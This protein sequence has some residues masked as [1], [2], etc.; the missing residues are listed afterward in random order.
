MI[1]IC[2]LSTC[3]ISSLNR[4]ILLSPS[5]A[6]IFYLFFLPKCLV[7]TSSAASDQSG[8]G[9]F[10]VWFLIPEQ[11]LS[12][13]HRQVRYFQD[14][15]VRP[16]LADAPITW[17]WFLPQLHFLDV[18]YSPNW[19]SV[20]NHA[21][22]SIINPTRSRR[23]TLVCRWAVL[24]RT[25]EGLC[26][27]S[28]WTLV[29]SSLHRAL[30]SGWCWPHRMNKEMLPPLQA[31][32]E[33]DKDQFCFFFKCLTSPVKPFVPGL[34]SCSCFCSWLV[35]SRFWLSLLTNDRSAQISSSS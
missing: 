20:R 1:Y 13:S 6:V 5:N 21:C 26:I 4:D 28:S 3:N 29:S 33:F 32:A 8:K 25:A 19:F 24:S 34:C 35:G 15:H 17:A 16:L 18:V 31:P 2:G 23:V 27:R 22:I 9:R 30:G 7:R 11:K 14:F 12:T 10:L